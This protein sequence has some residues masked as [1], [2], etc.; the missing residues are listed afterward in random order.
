M[1]LFV[2]GTLTEPRRV[3]EL[4]ESHVFVGAAT[5]RGLHP[6]KGRYPTLVPGGRVA[7][8]LLR[9]DDV[10]AVDA[11]EGVGRD[12]Y[13]RVNVPTDDGREVGVYVGD[14]MALD[15]PNAGEWPGD[16]PFAERVERYVRANDVRV[17]VTAE[18]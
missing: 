15:L 10:D 6:V 18:R 9:T 11:Y 5:L 16:G 7:G 2:Y 12:L 3:A 13:V 1:D 8:R 17:E 4:V 14:P